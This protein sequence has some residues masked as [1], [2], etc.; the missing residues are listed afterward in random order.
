MTAPGPNAS[1]GRPQAVSRSF[2]G[3][4][5]IRL[6]P[7]PVCASGAIDE[8]RTMTRLSLA[9]LG[10]RQARLAL[11]ERQVVLSEPWMKDP[12][13]R[14]EL[15]RAVPFSQRTSGPSYVANQRPLV[16]RQATG[17]TLAA[18]LAAARAAPAPERISFR[19][20]I[21]AFGVP[22]IEPVTQWLVD[23]GLGASLSAKIR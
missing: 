4:G 13:R 9:N 12:L 14:H 3:S 10:Q 5:L 17:M 23:P 7:G 11:D 8:E 15:T 6:T 22:A 1:R 16:G 2:G 21:A 18:T 20:R 19:D